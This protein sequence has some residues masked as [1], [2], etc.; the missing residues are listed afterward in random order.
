MIVAVTGAGVSAASGLSLYRSGDGLWADLDFQRMSNANQYGNFLDVLWP[1]WLALKSQC[2]N[3]EPN[4]LHYALAEMGWPVIT[5]NVDNLHQ[6]AGSV[7]VVEVHGSLQNARC[8]RCKNLFPLADTCPDCGKHRVRPD[9]VL[10][11]EDI[12]HRRL[13]IDYI[14]DADTVVYIGTSGNAHPVADWYAKSENSVLVDPNPWGY[15]DKTFAMTADQWV[16]EGCP[17]E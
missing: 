13:A 3:A 4:S 2:D 6:R 16:A 5:Q 12:K 15:F 11:G 10:F 17:T 14:R 7:D 8:L 1:K 9:I